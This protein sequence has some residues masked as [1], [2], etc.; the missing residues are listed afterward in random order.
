L[1]INFSITLIYV[2]R[3]GK[4]MRGER[5]DEEAINSI[6]EQ[7]KRNDIRYIRLIIVNLQGQPKAMLIPEYELEEALRYGKGF[8]GSSMGFTGIERS[9]L[10]AYPDPS[11][12]LIP[13]WEAPG[14]ALMFCYIYNPDGTP[15]EGDPRGLLRATVEELER[16]GYGF[17]T[18]PEV[19]FFYVAERNGSISPLGSGGY[20]DLPPLDP[21][22]EMKME[23]MM[24]LEAAG[25]QL[26]KAHHEAAPGQQEINFRFSDAL[27]TADNVILYKLAVKTIAQRYGSLATFMPKPFWGINGNGCHIHQSLIELETGRNLFHDPNSRTGLSEEALHYIGGLLSHAE[28]LSLVVSPTV[29]S[30]KRLIPHHEAP[31]YICWDYG[32]RS[33]IVRIPRYPK[34]TGKYT[35]IEYRHPDPS[36]NP[37]LASIAILKAGMDGIRRGADPGEPVSRNIYQLRD[38]ELEGM[39][40]RRLPRHLGEA[41]EA[42]SKD[43]IVSGALGGCSELLIRLKEREFEEYLSSVGDWEDNI[44]K[45][46][47][48]ELERYLTRC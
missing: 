26:D 12:L 29:N 46:T 1:Y 6:R 33:C 8:D 28:A 22:E 7:V 31:V 25:F 21:A 10:I 17:I 34:N 42:F 38:E 44:E 48:W 41:V 32:N 45:I 35:R 5:P 20:F 4:N 11:S 3:G 9:D 30:Y 15:F 39:G 37:Y 43:K 16:M 24:C 23:T 36:C 14:V 2:G 47:N 19:E 40:I 13:M 18:G 27:K